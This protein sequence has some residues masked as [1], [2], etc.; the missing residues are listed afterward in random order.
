MKLTGLRNHLE[1]RVQYALNIIN[2]SINIMK[3]LMLA[4]FTFGMNKTL[5]LRN[6][7]FF[8]IVLPQVYVT[9]LM[10]RICLISLAKLFKIGKKNVV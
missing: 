10:E 8:C 7:T 1:I 9:S 3:A 6:L 5:Y 4:S 2:V